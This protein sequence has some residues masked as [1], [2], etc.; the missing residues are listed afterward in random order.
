MCHHCSTRNLQPLLLHG[1]IPTK[2]TTL[3][4]CAPSIPL[5][6]HL[7]RLHHKGVNY[8]VVVDH[9]S[10]W[11]I[12]E[13]A[14]EGSK[15]LIDCLWCTFATFGIPDE[16]ATDGGPQFTA[17]ATCQFLKEWGVDHRLSSVV[18]PYSNC[19]V[20]I[21]AKTVK[22]IITDNTTPNGSLDTDSLQRAILQYRKTP[23]PNAQLS[24]AQ[25]VFGWPIKDFIPILP[26]RY[27]PQPT[28]SDTL[29]TREEALRNR[30]MKAA[31]RWSEHTKRLPPLAVGN[32]VRIQNQT[33]PYAIK[34]D[35]TGVV[36]E[37]CQCDQYV[38]HVDG[39]GRMTICN[40]KF[41]RKYIPVQTKAPRLTIDD[42]LQHLNLLPPRPNKQ[43]NTNPPPAALPPP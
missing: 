41:L 29:A 39:S 13:R 18:F 8:L 42:D 32:H 23:D 37:V 38:V 43:L 26:G 25:C 21:T 3:T 36:V 33:G 17:A 40:W 14:R 20:E 28:W 30:H 10:N 15:G 22:Q 16:C 7:C 35:K 4:N 24:P 6:M 9:Y 27:Q 19:R 11:P 5:P 12:V 1:T 31:K 34:W 2:C